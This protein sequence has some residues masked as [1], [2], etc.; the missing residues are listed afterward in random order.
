MINSRSLDKLNKNI[1]YH[2]AIDI[3]TFSNFY[4]ISIIMESKINLYK[5][6]LIKLLLIFTFTNI[7]IIFWK[8]IWCNK[9]INLKIENLYNS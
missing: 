8:I 1:I 9:L 6:T 3:L 7:K 2:N 4:K 5:L